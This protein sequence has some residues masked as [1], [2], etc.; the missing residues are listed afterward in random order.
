MPWWLWG[1]GGIFLLF[2]GLLLYSS[3][4]RPA[5]PTFAPT[6]KAVATVGDSV[7]D[8][9]ATLDARAHGEWTYFDLDLGSVVDRR[10]GGWDVAARR[11][12]VVVNAGPAFPGRA[13]A[14]AL[15][16][17]SPPE[18][19]GDEGVR[20][21]TV[22]VPAEGYEGTL[23]SGDG[24][25]T[26]PL[27]DWYRYDFFSHLLHPRPRLY[28][29]RTDEGGYALL[30]FLSYYCPGVEPGCVT[31]RYS[32]RRRGGRELPIPTGAGESGGEEP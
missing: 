19:S 21:P 30:R 17:P 14:M 26:P 4:R 18:A 20:L 27:E 32:Y 7:V 3:L 5:L 25:R 1:L 15:D 29:V 2:A 16:P 31:F 22:R 24:P 13:G 9:R 11:F 8:R 12:H 6:G 23:R 28:A 10:S